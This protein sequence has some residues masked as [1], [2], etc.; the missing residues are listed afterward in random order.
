MQEGGTGGTFVTEQ[1]KINQLNKLADSLAPPGS[2]A[3]YGR[4]R[5]PFD[6]SRPNLHDNKADFAAEFA[7]VSFALKHVESLIDLFK[8]RDA[9]IKTEEAVHLARVVNALNLAVRHGTRKRKIREGR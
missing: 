6:T 9:E 5:P 7:L 4:D 1:E 8:A 3:F 2:S